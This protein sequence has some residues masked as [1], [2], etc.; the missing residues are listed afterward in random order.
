MP[1]IQSVL[2]MAR[3]RLNRRKRVWTDTVKLDRSFQRLQRPGSG[4]PPDWLRRQHAVQEYDVRGFPCYTVRP[5]AAAGPKHVLYL[6]GGAYVHPPEPEH[7]SFAGRLVTELHCTVTLPLYPLAPRHQYDETL[8][9]VREVYEKSAGE[10]DPADQAVMGDSAGGGMTLVLARQLKAEGRAQPRDLVLIS[11]W[12]DITMT[13]PTAATIDR[14]DPYLSIPGLVEAGRL[15]SGT[16]D[17]NDPRLSPLA[18]ELDGLGRIS[19][20]TGTRDVLFPDSRRLWTKAQRCGIEI[21]YFEYED[22]FHGWVLQ[23]PLPEAQRATRQILDILR[24]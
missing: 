22:M 20:F 24:N 18:G 9:V 16:L 7:W 14:R 4:R 10:A 12:L 6:H 2:Y 5:Q 11:P 21:N 13:D 3:F 8:A 17:P 19:V 1:S 15:Y 23:Q